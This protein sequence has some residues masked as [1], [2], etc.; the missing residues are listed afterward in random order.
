MKIAVL[1]FTS[2]FLCNFQSLKAQEDAT[3]VAKLAEEKVKIDP[4]V[5]MEIKMMRS[6]FKTAFDKIDM[7]ADQKQKILDTIDKNIPALA[8]AKSNFNGV[9]TAEERKTYQSQFRLARVGNFSIDRAQSYALGQLKLSDERRIQYTKYKGEA[10]FQ[11]IKLQNEIVS[12]LTKE[13]VEKLPMFSRNRVKDY[14]IGVIVPRMKTE[15]DVKQA[16][17]KLSEIEGVK[18]MNVKLEEQLI[19]MHVRSDKKTQQAVSQ[20]MRGENAFELFKGFRFSYDTGD[21]L[22]ELL[23]PKKKK[24][25]QPTKID[26]PANKP[27]NSKDK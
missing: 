6:I 19:K 4:S 12:L 1:V 17:E 14:S 5:E 23:A 27:D 20:M 7:E 16:K 13:Q 10:D 3:N 8:T 15:D 18:V 25:V 26:K 24:K 11:D 21:G 2:L 22:K 9:L